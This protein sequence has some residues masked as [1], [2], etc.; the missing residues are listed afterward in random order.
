MKREFISTVVAFVVAVG[1]FSL[2][3]A[4]RGDNSAAQASVFS[5]AGLD[6]L[7]KPYSRAQRDQIAKRISYSADR[8]LRL[9]GRDVFEV[10]SQPELVR[11]DLPTVVWQYRSDS[12]VLD[13]FFTA[14]GENVLTEPVVHYEVR[15]RKR[16]AN[17][18]E[19]TRK[20]VSS[21]LG[22][23]ESADRGRGLIKPQAFYKAAL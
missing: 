16:D 12:C 7:G 21:L 13:I 10:L 17:V 2:N 1:I 15:A 9:S 4:L 23:H 14:S 5:T 8:I 22:A 6:D 3:Y 19:V 18:T 20:C 11:R